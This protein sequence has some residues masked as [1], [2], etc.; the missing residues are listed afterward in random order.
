MSFN[1]PPVTKNIIIINLL[2]Y[3]AKVVATRYGIDFDD[4]LGLHYF[5]ASDFRLYQLFTYMFVHGGLEHIFFNMFAV[6]MFGRIMEQVMGSQRFLFYYV[7]CGLGAGLAQEGVQYLEY[8]YDGLASYDR[9]NVG[10]G[11]TMAMED[12]L[13]RWTTVG[14]SGAVY[15][16]LLSFGMT[17]PEE[18]MFI[19]PFPFPIKAKWF[20]MGY[21]VIELLSALGNRGDGVAHM[22]HLGGMLF[23]FALIM[24]WR[25]HL[26]SG[27]GR[28]FGGGGG[29][30]GFGGYDNYFTRYEDVTNTSARQRSS[31]TAQFKQWWKNLSSKFS[32]KPKMKAQ[33]GGGHSKHA[34]DMEWHRQ[35]Q[36]REA[37]VDAILAKIK[38]G[39]YASLTDEEKRK[40]FEASQR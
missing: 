37:E 10:G 36:Q 29:Y 21:A 13:N 28:F 7:V 2:M 19:I 1:M 9:V 3:L 5:M 26:G 17:F 12:F 23:G 8:V 22:A 24:Y 40:L 15:G 31:F 39:G 30:G 6:W 35:Q 33:V 4:L 18:R 14:A 20:V 34:D 32:G 38:E 11:V 25:N 16:V 27:S